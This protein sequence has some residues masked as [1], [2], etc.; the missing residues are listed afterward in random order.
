MT[1]ILKNLIAGSAFCIISST[2]TAQEVVI[3]K[4][5]LP[6]AISSFVTTHFSGITISTVTKEIKSN[7]TEYELRLDNGTKLEFN[8]A[9]IQEIEGTVRIPNALVPKKIL[10]YVSKNYPKN[11]V[12]EWKID[13]LKQKVELDNGVEL[14]FNKAGKFLKI[15]I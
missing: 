15:D 6:S 2:M 14:E 10:E 1:N 9:T 4:Q 8:N 3:P 13:G 7:K 5:E 11:F 12:T